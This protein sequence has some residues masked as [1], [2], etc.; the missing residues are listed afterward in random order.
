MPIT[1]VPRKVTASTVDEADM[2]LNLVVEEFQNLARQDPGCGILVTRTGPGQ[3][4]VELSEQVP[5][6]LTWEATA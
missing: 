5:Y 4:T 2:L 6:G 3:F 1:L